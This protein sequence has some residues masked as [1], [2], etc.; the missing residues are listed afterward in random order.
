MKDDEHGHS[1]GYG[2]EGREKTRGEGAAR[3]G[4]SAP[5]TWTNTMQAVFAPYVQCM[6]AAT[7]NSIDLG[8]YSTNDGTGVKDNIEAIRGQIDRGSMP[9]NSGGIDYKAMWAKSNGKALFDQWYAAGY[10][11]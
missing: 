11:Q 9:R 5:V 8:Q 3:E 4:A 10:P 6:L 2:E 1:H 7:G